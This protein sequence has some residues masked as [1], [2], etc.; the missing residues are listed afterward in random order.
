MLVG[1]VLLIPISLRPLTRIVSTFLGP[2]LRV[3]GRLAEGQV[4]RRRGRTTLTV[5]VLFLA[6]SFG[7]GMANTIVDNV[8]DVG[9]ISTSTSL[10]AR[11]KSA[12]M[13]WRT[14]WALR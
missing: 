5:G 14:F 8:G 3:E 13:S 9:P 12:A 2:L 10:N 1:L 6:L 4:L 7:I 11:L